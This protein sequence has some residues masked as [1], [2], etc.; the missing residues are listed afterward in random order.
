MKD[1]EFSREEKQRIVPKI[2][3]YVEEELDIELGGFDAE[4]LL[5]FIAKEIG[6]YFYNRGVYDARATLDE[7]MEAVDEALLLLEKPIELGR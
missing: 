6:P 3:A 2:Q 7:R 5:D 1:I 4:F